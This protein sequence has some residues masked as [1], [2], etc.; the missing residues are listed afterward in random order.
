MSPISDNNKKNVLKMSNME[1][2]RFTKEC[3]QIALLQLLK[4]NTFEKITI[5]A[6]IE[7]AGVSRAGFYRNYS[8]KEKVLEDIVI[9]LSEKLV[10]FFK[11]EFSLT[12]PQQWLIKLFQE[13]YNSS[14]FFRVLI[15]ANVPHQSI[16]SIENYIEPVI[17]INTAYERYYYIAITTSIKEICIDW[18]KN[19]MKETPEEMANLIVEI[20]LPNNNPF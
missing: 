18:F 19:G 13:I 5:T 17:N 9:S 12:N 20:F 16:L 11:D 6:I 14:K 7:R 4:E 15:E 8:S 1:S 2:N 10:S 3:I